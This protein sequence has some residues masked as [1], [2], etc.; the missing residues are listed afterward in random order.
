[1]TRQTMNTRITE[2]STGK[3]KIWLDLDNSPHVPFFVPIIA[4]L[5]KRG[6]SIALTAR[7]CFQVRELAELFHLNYKLVG[8]H[9][10][11]SKIRKAFGLCFSDCNWFPAPSGRNRIWPSLMVRVPN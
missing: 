10:G 8:R 2:R 5:E 6:Y 9:N 7:D 3:P 11:K 4:E 1:L